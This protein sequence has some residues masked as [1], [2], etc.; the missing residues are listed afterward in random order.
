MYINQKRSTSTLS[1]LIFVK[2]YEYLVIKKID[3]EV[4]AN[5]FGQPVSFSYYMVITKTHIPPKYGKHT[6]GCVLKNTKAISKMYIYYE[7]LSKELSE[8]I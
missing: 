2:K 5:H 7:S 1:R 8:I 4:F 3:L 6:P